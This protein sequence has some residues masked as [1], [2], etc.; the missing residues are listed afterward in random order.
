MIKLEAYGL[1]LELLNWIKSFLENR[2][3]KVCLGEVS[4]DW[5]PVESGVP[6]GSVLGPLLFVMFINDLVDNIK[7]N[8]LL[9]ADDT[10]IFIKTDAQTD[11][12]SLSAWCNDWL[13]EFRNENLKYVTFYSYMFYF[14]NLMTLIQVKEVRYIFFD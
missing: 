6:Q 5:L 1:G 12:D 9:F 2:F 7:T 13:M 8:C 3:Q 10:N 11:L 14:F 4:S